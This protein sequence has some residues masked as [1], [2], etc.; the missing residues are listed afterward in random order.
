MLE[1]KTH[2]YTQKALQHA[3][4]HE[5]QT[6]E[7]RMSTFMDISVCFVTARKGSEARSKT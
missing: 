2:G 4:K 5:L 3:Q 6:R 1:Y 7:V